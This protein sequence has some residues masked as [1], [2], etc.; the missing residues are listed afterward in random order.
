MAGLRAYAVLVFVTLLFRGE[1]SMAFGLTMLLI[2]LALGFVAGYSFRA[3]TE[4]RRKH[5]TFAQDRAVGSE[6]L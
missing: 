6:R 2:N 3:A 5:Q 1:C 4:R